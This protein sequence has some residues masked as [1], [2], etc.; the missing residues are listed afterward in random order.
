MKV[1]WLRQC[2]YELKQENQTLKDEIAK[3]KSVVGIE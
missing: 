1:A 3:L 2:V